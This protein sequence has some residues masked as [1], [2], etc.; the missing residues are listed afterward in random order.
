MAASRPSARDLVE[1]CLRGTQVGG[2]E[3]LDEAIVDRREKLP[4]LAVA[5]LLPAQAGETE[6]GA[7]LPQQRFLLASDV[8][9]LV[10]QIF[11]R[12]YKIT[13]QQNFALVRSSS[14]K[15]RS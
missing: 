1:E 7:Q 5:A 9:R 15:K 11:R 14:A 2:L 3:A 4:C 13:P 12:R 6:G 10:E 8:E